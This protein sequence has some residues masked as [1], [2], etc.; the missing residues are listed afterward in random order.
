MKNISNFFITL[1]IVVT[2]S[3]VNL[4]HTAQQEWQYLREGKMDNII[5][6]TVELNIKPAQAFKYFVDN[7]LL[8][9]WLTVMANVEPTV[10]GKCELFWEPANK[11]DNS[12]IG[13]KITAFAEDQLIA[14]EWRSPKQ[15]KHFA[16]NADPLTHV[17]V[18][19]IPS[20]N[21]TIVH[22]I[23]S[24]WRSDQQWEVARIWQEKAWKLSLERLVKIVN[25]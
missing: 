2:L 6:L 8:E 20:E 23:H 3:N 7:K 22:V 10:G 21:T 4:L 11:D 13:C 24:G 17:V 16:N 5:H 9:S 19:L 18:S 15:F 25:Q 12:T 14:F 1:I